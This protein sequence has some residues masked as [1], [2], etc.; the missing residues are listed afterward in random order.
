M[1]RLR[2]VLVVFALS[3]AMVAAIPGSA[4]AGNFS[5]DEAGLDAAIAAAG[6]GDVG[7]HFF[8]CAV[9]TVVPLSGSKTLVDDIHLEG[10]RNLILSGQNTH[11]IFTVAPG[12]SAQLHEIIYI[13]GS[14]VNGAAISN[15]GELVVGG[16]EFLGNH[17]DQCGGAIATVA[18]PIFVADTFFEGN[19]A[20]TGGAI[21]ST[22]AD[23]L[24]LDSGFVNNHAVAGSGGAFAA[25]SE[26]I[27][28]E[29]SHF[30]ENSAA[31]SGGAIF[32]GDGTELVIAESDISGNTA[33]SGGGIGVDSPD[34]QFIVASHVHG[35][36]ATTAGGGLW[37]IGSSDLSIESTHFGE[38]TTDG[39]GGAVFAFD[40]N[41]EIQESQFHGNQAQSGGGIYVDETSME[42]WNSGFGGNHASLDGGALW[43]WQSFA[44]VG[45]LFFED[46]HADRRGGAIMNIGNSFLDVSD[47][48][49]FGNSAPENGGAIYNV[50]SPAGP[51]TLFLYGTHFEGNHAELGGAIANDLSHVNIGN[52]QIVGNHAGAEGGGLY[53]FNDA[54][55][56]ISDTMF[57]DNTAGGGGGGIGNADSDLFVTS[58]LAVGNSATF[59]GFLDSYGNGSAFVDN[60]ALLYNSAE[61]TGGAVFT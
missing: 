17:A 11:T 2:R 36:H 30:H 15:L 27:L 34:G 6:I 33:D 16:S 24:I 31:A 41:L 23:V 50:G 28:V 61:I 14:G 59:G 45:E 19:T 8:D 3:A 9:P 47:S 29:R 1:R 18:A 43:L 5:C 60:S 25:F 51:A 10:G 49:F 56:D 57:A 48:G 12:V 58:V 55:A 44:L 7:P 32:V 4:S 38:N 52:S 13:E 54:S 21:C 37:A 39:D 53:N 26:Q 40:A 46:N 22:D 20:L 35:N 42:M